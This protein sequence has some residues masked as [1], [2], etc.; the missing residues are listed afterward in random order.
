M[1]EVFLECTLQQAGLEFALLYLVD[2]FLAQNQ[3]LEL[4]AMIA[5]FYESCPD[6][7]TEFLDIDELDLL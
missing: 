6:I 4:M 3:A 2:V 7:V 5:Q 1:I